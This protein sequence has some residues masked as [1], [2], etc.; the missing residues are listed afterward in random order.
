MT[1]TPKARTDALDQLFDVL[2]HPYRR[3]IL[4][5]LNERNPRDE[6]SF[7]TDSVAEDT[8]DDDLVAV[9]IHHRHLPKL[10]KA[11]FVDWDHETNAVTRGSRFDEIAPLIEL[12][13][14]HRDEL[15]KGWP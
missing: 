11:G 7:S 15:P 3:R 6:A 10:A 14:E 2:S 12:M 1:P 9:E 13:D 8:D 5:R 4:T